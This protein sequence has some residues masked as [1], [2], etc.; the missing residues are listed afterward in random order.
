MSDKGTS[1]SSMSDNS[2]QRKPLLRVHS[3]DYQQ[4]SVHSVA[5][6]KLK[7][8][9]VKSCDKLENSRR[10]RC[11]RSAS[12][13]GVTKGSDLN[14]P[15]PPIRVLSLD[16]MSPSVKADNEKDR[17]LK[18]LSEGMVKKKGN[19]DRR[20]K[21]KESYPNKKRRSKDCA[22]EKH[23]QNGFHDSGEIS[24]KGVNSGEID[25]VEEDCK[26]V[27]LTPL[28]ANAF[29]QRAEMY[30][31]DYEAGVHNGSNRYNALNGE[32]RDVDTYE[33]NIKHRPKPR[34]VLDDNFLT[35]TEVKKQVVSAALY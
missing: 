23:S 6:S 35:E 21:T 19:V 11:T 26:D 28:K 3:P 29:S 13:S 2:G 27:E 7:D 4:S 5:K 1:S 16:L 20:Y 24:N 25:G 9:S 8:N 17:D 33:G 10:D 22:I 12:P 30:R 32:N 34:N 18:L 14:K 31:Q 15:K